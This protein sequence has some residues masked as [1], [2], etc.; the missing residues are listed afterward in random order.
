MNLN[1]TR[2]QRGAYFTPSPVARLLARWAVLSGADSVLDPSAGNGQLLLAAH[3]RLREFGEV[4]PANL[5]GVELH[6]GTYSSLLAVGSRLGIPAE[7]LQ[8]S[9]FF[10]TRETLG[11]MDAV[12]INPPYVRHH[13][14]PISA[15]RRMKA[16]MTTAGWPIDGK[17]SSWAYF[18]VSAVRA[19]KPGGRLAAVL[20]SELF[21]SDYGRSILEFLSHHFVETRA[22][23]CGSKI[24]PDLQIQAVLINAQGYRPRAT[25]AEVIRVGRVEQPFS[26]DSVSKASLL[27][28]PSNHYSF[29]HGVSEDTHAK[30]LLRTVAEKG[31]LPVGQIAAVRIG[32]VS[33]AAGF[34]QLSESQRREHNISSRDLTRVLCRGTHVDGICF[35]LSDWEQLRALDVPCWLL[36]PK[37]PV[38][39]AIRRMI[40]RGV[41]EG[42]SH[43]AKC[44]ARTPWWAIQLHT[45]PSIVANYLGGRIRLISNSANAQIP[46]T[47][48]GLHE[49]EPTV[50]S[51][52]PIGSMTSVFQ[53][54]VALH[55]RKKG[56]G[57]VK[58]EPS[59]LKRVLIP[60]GR[61]SQQTTRE[62]DQLVRDGDWNEAIRVAD[63]F[64]L[65][66][67]LGLDH[68]L[69]AALAEAREKLVRPQCS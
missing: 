11:L 24:F 7:N 64:V 62:V 51:R 63:D 33:G 27:D 20:P 57:L 69:I 43:N 2:R 21:T 12:V 23:H 53:L 17:A 40:R 30:A 42:I 56:A 52:L 29:G 48:Y 47:L 3:E 41:T 39:D 10:G 58:L 50:N 25:Q 18:I 55:A 61:K 32:Y 59:D 45:A 35:S 16:S 65:R 46:N 60:I 34:F 14:I 31:I 36:T 68:K 19:L 13:A 5:F 66:H 49:V 28:W 54:S 4:R 67:S 22:Y 37:R 8:R 1:G 26:E 9:D 6:R 38:S 44:V 15:L